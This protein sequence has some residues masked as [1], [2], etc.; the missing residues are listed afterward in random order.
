MEPAIIVCALKKSSGAIAAAS[1]LQVVSLCP[2]ST[3]V[4]RLCYSAVCTHKAVVWVRVAFILM[5]YTISRN[6]RGDTRPERIGTAQA[7]EN[8]FEDE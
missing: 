6:L 7:Y 4:P 5:V 1:K 2:T 8:N 3:P